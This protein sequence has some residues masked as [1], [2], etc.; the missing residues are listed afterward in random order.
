LLGDELSLEASLGDEGRVLI[1]ASTTSSGSCQ[2]AGRF[3]PIGGG[4]E[5]RYGISS[6]ELRRGFGDSDPNS[7]AGQGVA[8]EGDDAVGG[9]SNESTTSSW[10]S[11]GDVEFG[12]NFHR[13]RG[14]ASEEGSCGAQVGGRFQNR[15]MASGVGCLVNEAG[16]SSKGTPAISAQR[17]RLRSLVR[18][19]ASAL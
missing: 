19:F 14:Y 7:L 18:T 1:V 8:H 5:D 2:C 3:H 16:T 15:T 12:A 17:A 6:E 10:F 11:D 4:L 13:H 9:S